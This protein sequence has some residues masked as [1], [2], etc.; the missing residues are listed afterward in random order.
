MRLLLITT[1]LAGTAFAQRTDAPLVPSA[2]TRLP[3]KLA[4]F[5]ATRLGQFAYVY[6]GHSGRT[7]EFGPHAQSGSFLRLSLL[8][9]HSWEE[10]PSDLPVQG[11]AL[12]GRGRKLFRIGGLQALRDQGGEVELRSTSSVRMFDTES[13]QWS[14]ET[15][16]PEPRSSHEAYVIDDRVY[17]VGGWSHLNGEEIWLDTAWS[18]DLKRSPL[19]WESMPKP[20]SLRRAY[21]MAACGDRLAILGGL[22]P[23]GDLLSS[24]ELFDPKTSS[25]STGPSLPARGFGA[26]A[27]TV[28]GDLYASGTMSELFRL[29]SDGDAFESVADYDTARFFDRLI[30]LD[31]GRIAALAGVGA[32]DHMST[33]ELLDPRG[34]SE[35]RIVTWQL[36]YAGLA[37]NRQGLFVH[38]DTIWTFGGN[39]TTEQHAFEEENFLD[40]GHAFHLATMTASRA[41]PDLPVHRQSLV[42]AVVGGRR[43]RTGFA[44]GG[45]GH[46]GEVE[47][48]FADVFR[49]DFKSKEWTK[50]AALP[51]SRTQFQLAVHD[52]TLWL[53]G[54]TDYDPRRDDSF[55]YP[56]EVLRR[57][58]ASSG[59]FEPAG[60]TMP[61]PRRAFGGAVF[62]GRFWLVGGM[63]EDFQLV[64]QVDVFD[65]ESGTFTVGPMPAAPRISPT[66]ASLGGRLYLALGTSPDGEGDFA[67]NR[68]V[69]VYEPGVGWRTL[70]EELPFPTRHCR[71]VV[72]GERLV[73]FSTHFEAGG[74]AFVAQL[75]P[76]LGEF[77]TPDEAGGER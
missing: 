11:T 29:R 6:G 42:T 14:E 55:R 12:V 68:S 45:F 60:V 24:V 7:H 77:E 49:F 37:K 50:D 22:S 41:M 16:L 35:P 70:I 17:V 62:D 47:R 69:E 38:Q 40:E 23:D 51:G 32:G 33:I 56:T 8:D 18:A 30:P 52:E 73:F 76:N 26:S 63:R 3:K 66:L 44:I 65:F 1:L 21:A 67:S 19:V 27:V 53:F 28:D 5:G 36:P 74:R 58:V 34:E 10:L 9:L 57:S 20:S 75:D 39:Q 48:S 71:M 15:P 61:N 2:G 64:E 25:W 31:D 46:D 54:G 13:M 43:D 4:S 72:V 59:G